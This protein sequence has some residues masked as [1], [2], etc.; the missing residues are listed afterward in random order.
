[1]LTS[2]MTSFCDSNGLR[3]GT[4]HQHSSV[5]Y[6]Y[7][8]NMS[9]FS[10][11]HQFLLSKTLST[12]E[13]DCVCSLRDIDNMSDHEPVVLHLSVKFDI[14]QYVEKIRSAHI[15]WDKAND[16]DLLSIAICYHNCWI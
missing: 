10:I 3:F 14:I 2:M 15:S 1:M 4:S 5:D 11:I 16:D 12:K 6:T 7:Q 9:R 13:I 8:F